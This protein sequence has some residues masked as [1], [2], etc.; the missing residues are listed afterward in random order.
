[1]LGFDV[2][3]E[4]RFNDKE[5]VVPGDNAFKVKLLAYYRHETGC[6]TYR[7][8][9]QTVALLIGKHHQ[10]LVCDF[11]KALRKVFFVGVQ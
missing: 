2:T 9:G 6:F 5:M 11:S 10:I 4:I 8:G 1:M 3:G 7:E